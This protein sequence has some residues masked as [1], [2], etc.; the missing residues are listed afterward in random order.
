MMIVSANL[1][2]TLSA[3]NSGDSLSRFLHSV[4]IA[5]LLFANEFTKEHHAPLNRKKCD[6]LRI[7]L[8]QQMKFVPPV[9][10]R[11]IQ[12]SR[13]LV[14]SSLHRFVQLTHAA[15]PTLIQFG[16]HALDA[17]L[18][19]D[20]HAATLTLRDRDWLCALQWHESTSVRSHAANIQQLLRKLP[21][22]LPSPV[23]DSIHGIPAAEEVVAPSRVPRLATLVRLKLE[24]VA[25]RDEKVK[26][27]FNKLSLR[28]GAELFAAAPLDS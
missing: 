24:Q 7:V 12:S 28:L 10:L 16:T 18:A 26:R 20:Y 5:E 6:E 1:I 17:A 23:E 8:V 4:L 22:S 25:S 14:W 11:E 3:A 21:D 13:G 27:N 19:A 9:I 15:D 2:P